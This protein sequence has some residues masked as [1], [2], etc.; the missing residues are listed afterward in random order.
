[1][2]EREQIDQI[3]HNAGRLTGEEALRV[4]EALD[5]DAWPYVV[6]TARRT[7]FLPSHKTQNLTPA[8]LGLCALSR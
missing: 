2:L 5:P 1:M 3:E 4:V 8:V 7:F 6:E